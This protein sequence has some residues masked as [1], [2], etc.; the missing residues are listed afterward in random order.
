[1]TIRASQIIPQNS[2][3]R[4]F[5][6]T[7]AALTP[8]TPVKMGASDGTIQAAG[9][10]EESIGIVIGNARTMRDAASQ[11][12]NPNTAWY[13]SG[14][15]AAR[16]TRPNPDQIALGAAADVLL[17]GQAV[18]PMKVGAAGVTRGK[19]VVMGA[20]GVEDAP[21]TGGGT[22]ASNTIGAALESGVAN[23]YVSIV[24]G[25]DSRTTA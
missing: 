2:L 12:S 9:A 3:I 8:N 1:M 7:V 11:I 16:G 20:A 24:V 25:R 19:R 10:N 5:T 14:A 21:A 18:L 17:F 15:D 4:A 6:V 23:D 13:D 22:V